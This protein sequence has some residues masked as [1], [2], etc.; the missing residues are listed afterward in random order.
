MS[1]DSTRT[2]ILE[3]AGPVF[4]DRGYEE[5]T[6]REICE[7]AEVNLAAVNY[8]FGGKERLYAE[9]L[10]RVHSR[11]QERVPEWPPGTP[12][13][14]KL[15]HFIRRLL[16]RL[17]RSKE[18]PWEMRLMM[19]EIMD[20]T[21]AG[22]KALQ[23]HFRRGFDE[24]Q[25][26]L[27]EILPPE[28][29][30]FKRHQIGFSITSQ[31]IHYH[32]AGPGRIV[33]LL[34]GPDELQQHFSVEQLAGHIAEVSLAALGLGPPLVGTDGNGTRRGARPHFARKGTP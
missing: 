26:I 4:A 27:D 16:T 34:I 13:A 28:T 31:C 5:A 14:E 9:T 33:A 24:L 3:A 23:N 21:T 10:E 20:P 2:R 12:P 17:L 8:Y 22:R 25:S 6:V 7:K 19:R 1:N 29:P 15:K 11:Q 30:P 18:E 32:P